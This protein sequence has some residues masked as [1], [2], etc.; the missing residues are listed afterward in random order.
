MTTLPSPTAS[1]LP[2]AGIQ[3]L[4]LTRLLP[5][6]MATMQLADLGASVL[7]IE[8]P[9]L[10]DYARG[11]GPLRHEVSQL[12]V[13]VNRGKRMLELDLKS[14][15]GRARLLDL[16]EA[17]DVL[18]ESFRPGVMEK[19]G[20]G[21]ERLKRRNPRLVMCAI[22]GYGQD[23]PYA[24]MAGHDLNYLALS[25]VL[26][27]NAG[28]DGRPALCNLQIADLLGGAQPAVQGILAALVAVKMGQP[29]RYVDVAMAE[30][31][32]AHNV[33]PLVAVNGAGED[34]EGRPAPPGRDILT[35]G[36][37]CYRV[38]RTRD[39]R[40]MALGAL[41]YKFWETCCA[42]LG[43]SDL[44]PRHWSRGQEVG[45]ADAMAVAAELDALF[46]TRTLAEWTALFD[47][48]DACVTPVL[49]I[50]E[51]LRHPLFT[52]RGSVRRAS[53]PT[54]GPYWEAAPSLRMRS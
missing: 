23:G 44:A 10:G 6:P 35:G 37:P 32:L 30:C 51:A 40:W 16:V 52:A 15:E 8:G 53:H 25:G 34:G 20:L 1:S 2:L 36:V 54:E 50:D 9:G 4:D 14:D 18:V 43:R 3:V 28:P 29:G 13:A 42:T 33:M 11:M 24:Q 22:S 41:E 38:Y 45:G 31:A 17:S 39:E 5:G 7:K 21:W 19:L 27:Q 49:R 48:V 12:F 46:A 47:G 26:E